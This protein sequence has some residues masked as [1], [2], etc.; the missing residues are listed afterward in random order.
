MKIIDT[1]IKNLR[2]IAHKRHCDF[3]GS[4]RE[5]YIKKIINW[6]KFLFEYATVSKKMF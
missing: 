4:L 3:R 6:D 2:I 1:G 5:T